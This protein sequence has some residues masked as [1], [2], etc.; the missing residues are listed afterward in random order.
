VTVSSLWADERVYCPLHVRPYTPGSRV[1]KG[2][3]DPAFRTKPQLALELIEA[4]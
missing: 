3:K 2:K 4:A 1:P